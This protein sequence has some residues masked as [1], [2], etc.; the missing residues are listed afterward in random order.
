MAEG[1]RD[2]GTE[3]DGA[4]GRARVRNDG[5]EAG[6]GGSKEQGGGRMEEGGEWSG[7]RVRSTGG[8]CMGGE[9]TAEDGLFVEQGIDLSPHPLSLL[10]P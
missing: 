8:K 7:A 5:R 6:G 10:A 2:G 9:R 3:R 1:R 4:I